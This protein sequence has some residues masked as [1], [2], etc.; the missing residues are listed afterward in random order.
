MPPILIADCSTACRTDASSVTSAVSPM[1]P[2]ASSSGGLRSSTAT[3]APRAASSRAVASPIPE[4]PPVTT[5]FS[6]LSSAIRCYLS[7][8]VDSPPTIRARKSANRITAP[9]MASIQ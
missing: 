8:A 3:A 5:A 1:K 2:S 7:S 4:P 6:P 9:S